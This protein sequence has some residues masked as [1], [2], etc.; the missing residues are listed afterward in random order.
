MTPLK[1]AG[2]RGSADRIFRSA[3]TN[4]SFRRKSAERP[5]ATARIIR[6]PVTNRSPKIRRVSPAIR[7]KIH[8]VSP[9]VSVNPVKSVPTK[10]VAVKSIQDKSSVAKPDKAKS[11]CKPCQMNKLKRQQKYHRR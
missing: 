11:G 4:M 3:R 8:R 9:A 10:P 1:L 7:P 6:A 2:K 5:Q